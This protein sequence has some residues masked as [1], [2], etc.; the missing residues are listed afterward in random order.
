LAEAI[1]WE[2][3]RLGPGFVAEM[4]PGGAIISDLG[5]TVW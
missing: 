5:D 4:S 1:G 2:F 3:S